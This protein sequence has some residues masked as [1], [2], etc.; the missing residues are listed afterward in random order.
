MTSKS[1][2]KR[3][4]IQK[5]KVIALSEV[6]AD[7]PSCGSKDNWEIILNKSV[8]KELDDIFAIQ[9]GCGFRVEFREVE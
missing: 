3:L 1:T 9:C 2:T 4:K 5:A 8:L 6:S 7:C